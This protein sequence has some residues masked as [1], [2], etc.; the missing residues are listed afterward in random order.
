M[1][2]ALITNKCPSFPTWAENH[3][4]LSCREQDTHVNIH[5]NCNSIACTRFQLGSKANQPGAAD[6]AN[7]TTTMARPL[8]IE[9]RPRIHT[10]SCSRANHPIARHKGPENDHSTIRLGKNR[11][12]RLIEWCQNTLCDQLFHFLYSPD[13]QYQPPYSNR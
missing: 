4:S 1:G 7:L 3:V 6:A 2:T 5:G 9:C 12:A 10:S 11:K 8:N 13:W